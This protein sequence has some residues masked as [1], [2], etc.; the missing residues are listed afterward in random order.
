MKRSKATRFL[1]LGS[2]VFALLVLILSA[3]P[4]HAELQQMPE[5]I[6]SAYCVYNLSQDMLLYSENYDAV[7]APSATVK[8]MSGIL[9]FEYFQGHTDDIVTVSEEALRGVSGNMMSPAL[10]AG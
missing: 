7:I 4:A 5:I 10:K 2:I 8:I 1:R 9:A 6:G 3:V